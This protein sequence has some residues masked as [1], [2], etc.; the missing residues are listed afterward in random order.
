MKDSLD[1][2]EIDKEKTL[3]YY[4]RIV[5]E[6]HCDTHEGFELNPCGGNI[7]KRKLY[8]MFKKKW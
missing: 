4:S 3:L 5:G 1:V 7:L 2:E 6:E 8:G